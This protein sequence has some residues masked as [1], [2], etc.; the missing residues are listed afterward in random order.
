VQTQGLDLFRRSRVVFAL[1]AKQESVLL[2]LALMLM[3]LLMDC[4]GAGGAPDTIVIT[5][6]PESMEV[7][8]TSFVRLTVE[9]SGR[10]D[11]Y[12]WMNSN[13][14]VIAQ[15]GPGPSA[16]L[17]LL[18]ILN[19]LSCY[20]ILTN[21]DMVVTSGMAMVRTKMVAPQSTWK[22]R[23]P[24]LVADSKTAVPGF[25]EHRFQTLS[26]DSL[27][28]LSMYPVPTITYRDGKVHFVART[29]G[30]A[31]GLFRF[32]DGVLRTLVYT[33][34][35]ASNGELVGDV[36]S[37]S[38]EQ[39][40]GVYFVTAKRL[41]RW[42]ES[43]VELVA[44]ETTS[45]PS[46]SPRFFLSAG[47]L[48]GRGDGLAFC[49]P[50]AIYFRDGGDTN[51]IA[52]NLTDLPGSNT[53][54][55]PINRNPGGTPFH[56]TYDGQSI[57]FSSGGTGASGLYK[58]TPAGD[59]AKLIDTTDVIPGTTSQFVL[60]SRA[61]IDGGLAFG[62]GTV[63]T[64]G[65]Q[66]YAF[67][68]E[69]G[70]SR[71]ASAT[72][73][74]AAGSNSVYHCTITPRIRRWTGGID[75][76]VADTQRLNGE[77]FLNVTW[78][79]G[80]GD[81]L[82][83]A[84]KK[85]DSQK[86]YLFSG[87]V[88]EQTAPIILVEPWDFQV[89]DQ[90]E[91]S[92]AVTAAG[93]PPLSFQWRRGTEN[94]AGAT[95]DLLTL[96]VADASMAGDYSV[97]VTNRFGSITSQVARLTVAIPSFFYAVPQLYVS[98]MLYGSDSTLIVQASGPRPLTFQWRT[99][100]VVV[101]G[102]TE[103]SYQISRLTEASR[104]LYEAEVSDGATSIVASRYLTNIVPAIIQQP[105]PVTSVMGST[106]SFSAEAIGIPPLTY[107]W[108]RQ[109]G[110]EAFKLNGTNSTLILTNISKGDA[111]VYS[112]VVFSEAI[113]ANTSE[114]VPLVVLSEDTPAP[115][116]GQPRLSGEGSRFEFTVPTETGRTYELQFAS[117]LSSET[118]WSTLQVF[119][120]DGTLRLLKL[121]IPTSQVFYRVSRLR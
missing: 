45:L 20:V 96:P 23:L 31:R 19:D 119:Y 118:S 115:V 17:E 109:E 106:V 1:T 107:Q 40:G 112:V 114:A 74:S 61:D 5:R 77:Q 91:A 33:N 81:D 57:V 54:F 76:A 43:G 56:L 94:V 72:L 47:P 78:I 24:Q 16:T 50:S 117:A 102:A 44:D 35:R 103:R 12:A 59:I 121:P 21:S 41:Y 113:Q 4:T 65:S 37:S 108:F 22:G 52:D 9:G 25:P 34:T 70:I 71:I 18:S 6:Q 66:L 49:T 46:A 26:P 55:R 38:D 111:G 87:P 68:G 36:I 110:I 69:G 8:W 99:N 63:T 95:N 15:S 100:G 51:L 104:G 97:V 29:T 60:I 10:I 11:G 58:A 62:I 82:A 98:S 2:I 92:F 64:G 67:D 48:S 83:F 90:R 42:S 85:I 116:L 86:I 88:R 53:G 3:G 89:A 7:P 93:A 27:S 79:D 75:E 101:P 105:R 120:G 84:V 30:N 32:A 80:Q 39:N 28:D 73:L 14:G 13:G